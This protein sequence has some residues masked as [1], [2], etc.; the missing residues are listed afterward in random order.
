MNDLDER[1]RLL[2]TNK[3]FLVQAPFNE[4]F[5]QRAKAELSGKWNSDFNAWAF[6]LRDKARALALVR[7]IYRKA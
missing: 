5:N 1:V 6:P 4:E 3:L 7:W 2:Q